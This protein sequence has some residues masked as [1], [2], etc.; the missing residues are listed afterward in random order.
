MSVGVCIVIVTAVF[1][2]VFRPFMTTRGRVGQTDAGSGRGNRL[3]EDREALYD[4]IRELDFDY[5]MGKVEEDDY[6]ATRSRY[7]GRAIELMRAI[8]ETAGPS[9]EID[10]RIEREIAALRRKDTDTCAGCGS[11]SPAGARFCPQCG[12]ALAES[13]P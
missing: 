6:R 8:E 9:P 12:K 10:E 4:A 5:R 11:A 2:F 13:R 3:I 1:I 7:E